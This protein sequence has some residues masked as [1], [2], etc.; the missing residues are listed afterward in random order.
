M[1]KKN[2]RNRKGRKPSGVVSLTH[3]RPI[4]AYNLHC[5]KVLRFNANAAF[6]GNISYQNLL[7]T[8]LVKASATAVYDVFI[9]VRI[10]KVEIWA[11]GVLGA[12]PVTA[13]VIF[14]VQSTGYTGD[15]KVH[16]DSS[17]G[18]EPAHV[19]ARP[20]AKSLAALYQ[21]SSGTTA[22]T[23]VVPVSAVVDVHVDFIGDYQNGVAAQNT[24]ASSGGAGD[25]CTRGLDGLAVATSKFTT[26]T[27]QV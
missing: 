11:T 21:A 8:M 12:A 20:S 10:R 24:A 16:T 6:S 7:D 27:D 3:P 9:A 22:F 1:L 5:S 18:L 2:N 19:V 4:Q 14:S 15:Q 26:P 23:L 13:T 17:M 25:F